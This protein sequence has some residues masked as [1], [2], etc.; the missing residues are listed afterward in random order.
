MKIRS[1]E[2][3]VDMFPGLT[4]FERHVKFVESLSG[5]LSAPRY[6]ELLMV[7]FPVKEPAII[8]LPIGL[9]KAGFQKE[10]NKRE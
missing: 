10:Q 4:P 1:I 6:Q 5:P 8:V 7:H 3:T 2:R 9:G